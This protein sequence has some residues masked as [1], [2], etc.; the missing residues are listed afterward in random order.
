MPVLDATFPET[1]MVLAAAGALAILPL[2][3][4]PIV[5]GLGLLMLTPEM[6]PPALTTVNGC[7][8]ADTGANG[9]NIFVSD[10]VT[11]NVPPPIALESTFSVAAVHVEPAA[12]VTPDELVGENTD[13]MQDDAKGAPPVCVAVKPIVPLRGMPANATVAVWVEVAPLLSDSVMEGDASW[14]T[15]CFVVVSV[16]PPAPKICRVT[17]KGAAEVLALSTVKSGAGNDDEA[18][19]EK[20]GFVPAGPDTVQI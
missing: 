9:K 19:P 18:K 2:I 8:D 16:A 17:M 11:T 15:I 12:T 20:F 5:D 1:V 7:V 6:P 4:H 3:V 10:K 13:Q 14:T